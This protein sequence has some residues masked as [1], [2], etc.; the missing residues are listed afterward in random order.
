MSGNAAFTLSLFLGFFF[1][2]QFCPGVFMGI[3]SLFA[4]P[5]IEIFLREI[6]NMFC[7][8]FEKKVPSGFCEGSG[9]RFFCFFEHF[10]LTRLNFFIAIIGAAWY[11]KS[12]DHI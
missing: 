7:E 4:P 11:N 12:D 10:S 5:L 8:F 9:T 1:C 2:I 3:R 6:S